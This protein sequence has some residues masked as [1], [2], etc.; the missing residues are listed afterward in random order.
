VQTSR[1]SWY[2]KSMTI[3]ALDFMNLAHRA[4]SGFQAG[5]HAVVFNFFRQFKSL[6]DQFKPSRVYIILEG[7]PVDRY[8]LLAEYKAN[9]KVAEDD[10]RRKELDSFFRQ[11]DV[12]LELL[13]YFPACVAK[14]PRYECD[15]TIANLAKHSWTTVPWTIVS[16]DTDFTQLLN[17]CE[18][19]SIWNP[20]KKEYVATPDYDYVTWKSL[21][22]DSSDNIPGIPG[23]GEVTATKLVSDPEALEKYLQD[24]ARAEVFARNYELISFREWTDE[25]RQG[26]TSSVGTKDWSAVLAKFE[27]FGFKSITKPESWTKFVSAFEHL[28][29]E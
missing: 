5:D 23:C 11:K 3:L 2:H 29:G 1:L 21:K 13:K 20:V 8:E 19:V 16:S 22:G 17:T 24:P 15:D 26:M 10:P 4:R 27:E 25:D 6:V 18:H 12:I 7:K 9:R 14:H 28:W